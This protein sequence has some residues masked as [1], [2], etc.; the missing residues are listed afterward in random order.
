MCTCR[1]SGRVPGLQRDSTTNC[2]VPASFRRTLHDD[3]FLTSG[4]RPDVGAVGGRASSIGPVGQPRRRFFAV[5]ATGSRRRR[6]AA[7]VPRRG[8]VV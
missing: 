3:L 7:P 5:V 4:I 6:L 8:S 1:G 2:R